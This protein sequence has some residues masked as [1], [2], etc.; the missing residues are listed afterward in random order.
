MARINVKIATDKIVEALDKK[1]SEIQKAK[2]DELKNKEAYDKAV[3]DWEAKI[4]KAIP[5]KPTAV[6]VSQNHYRYDSKTVVVS[7][8]FEVALDK[9]P[10]KPE[11]PQTIPDYQYREMVEEIGNAIRI[12]KLTDQTE[13]STSTYNSVAKYL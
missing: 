7:Q 12:L 5:A 1:L 9:L 8:R 4:I 10:K 6:E 3:K 2:A 13:V 11:Q